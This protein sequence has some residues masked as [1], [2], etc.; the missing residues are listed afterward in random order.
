MKTSKILLLKPSE[1][2]IDNIRS[3]FKNKKIFFD[4]KKTLCHH[5]LNVLVCYRHLFFGCSKMRG[6][7][8]KYILKLASIFDIIKNKIFL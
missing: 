7:Q 1:K 6:H 3:E 5:T 8:K 2:E 4:V